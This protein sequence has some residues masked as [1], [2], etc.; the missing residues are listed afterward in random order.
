MSVPR[1]SDLL[2][3]G[4][5]VLVWPFFQGKTRFFEVL[6]SDT[7]LIAQKYLYVYEAL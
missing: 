4:D 2:A 1:L 7:G 3:K 5:S 6:R